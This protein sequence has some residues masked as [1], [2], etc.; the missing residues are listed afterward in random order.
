MKNIVSLK[1]FYSKLYFIVENKVGLEMPLDH[2]KGE[3]ERESK[4]FPSLAGFQKFPNNKSLSLSSNIAPPTRSLFFVYLVPTPKSLSV[5]PH[6]RRL[7][8]RHLRRHHFIYST[9]LYPS[10]SHLFWTVDLF[11]QSDLGSACLAIL[12]CFLLVDS[13]VYLMLNIKSESNVV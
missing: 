1:Y 4:D 12:W 9:F 5:V 6:R 8:F 10:I 2:T 13:Q 3:R 7:Q 11:C